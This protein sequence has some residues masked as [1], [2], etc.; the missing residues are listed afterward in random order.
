VLLRFQ[1]DFVRRLG[2]ATNPDAVFV[3]LRR[4]LAP[5]K[6]GRVA[7]DSI[8]P[9]LDGGPASTTAIYGLIQF[10][11]EMQVTS[12]L[13]FP[14]DMSGLYDRRLEPLMQRP[15]VPSESDSERNH[16][17]REDPLRSRIHPPVTF[18]ILRRRH[19][20]HHRC[21]FRRSLCP[22]VQHRLPPIN[23]ADPLPEL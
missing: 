18:R 23:M 16:K 1:L 11:D 20:G 13:T 21:R 10:L 3:E 17:L 9:F 22:D 7:I 4:Q 2:R 5:F 6:C 8:V 19:G 14:G 12:L 15:A